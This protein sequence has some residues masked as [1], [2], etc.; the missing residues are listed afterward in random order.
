[1]ALTAEGTRLTEAHRLAQLDISKQAL[2]DMIAV[3][4]LLDPANVDATFPGYF[5]AA[6]AIIAHYKNLSASAAAQYYR[7]FRTAEGIVGPVDVAFLSALANEQA[8]T[9]LL[10]T[11]PIAVKVASRN[12]ASPEVAAAKAFTQTQGAVR[13]L[14]QEG[15]RDTLDATIRRDRR[16]IGYARVTDGKPCAFCAMLASRGAVYKESTV[17]FRAHDHCGCTS[18]PVFR[19]QDY[20]L[21]GRAK[22]F[23]DLWDETGGKQ[24]GAA[25]LAAFR[26]AYRE[27]YGG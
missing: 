22:E 1:M 4:R 17:R 16:A 11:G 3:W 24:S 8:M 12:G 23:A 2:R 9:S 25:A 20:M 19:T 21:P 26:A 14:V 18:E 10:V 5:Q 27:R 15:G 6:K 7:A 13:R